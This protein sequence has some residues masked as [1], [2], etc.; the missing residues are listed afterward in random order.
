M[1][2]EFKFFPRQVYDGM[3][4]LAILFISN[5]RILACWMNYSC[6]HTNAM[7]DYIVWGLIVLAFSLLLVQSGKIHE[8]GRM[9]RINWL[10]GLFILYSVASIS[11]SIFPERSV[12]TVYIMIASSLTASVLAVIYP[13]QKLLKTLFNFTLISAI[14]SLLLVIVYPNLGIHQ[15]VVWHGA[16]RGIFG[17]K[18]DFGPIMA[19]GNGLALLLLAPSTQ[20][21]DLILYPAAYILTLFLIIMSRC[22]TALVLWAILSGFCV[23][24]FIWIKWHSKF[25][26]KNLPYIAGL[27][28]ALIFLAPLSFLV[29]SFLTGRSFNLTGRIPLW[30]NL[31]TNVVSKKPWFGYGLETLWYVPEFQKW[32][33]VTS[34][35]GDLIVVINGHNGYMDILLYLGIVGL[36]VLCMVLIIGLTRIAKRA[37]I[38]RTWLDFSPLL[39]LMYVLI[40]NTTIDYMLEFESFHWVVLVVILFLPI[41]KFPEQASAPSN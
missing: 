16:W 31:L 24:Y 39:V 41:G 29:I 12:H 28:A 34:G 18:N 32:A 35:W 10:L 26:S 27:S 2:S 14:L 38:G 9:W 17:H 6:E 13:L 15:D 21:K 20:K 40:A 36:A 33:S 3:L 7:S 19:L 1:K 5:R 23:I 11:W 25:Q 4:A 37:F 30:I 22:A 8:Y